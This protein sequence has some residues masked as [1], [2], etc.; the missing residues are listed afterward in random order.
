MHVMVSGLVVVMW[1]SICSLSD[2]VTLSERGSETVWERGRE[3]EHVGS[4][5]ERSRRLV[6]KI[7]TF[8]VVHC[9]TLLSICLWAGQRL[10]G[11]PLGPCMQTSC[12]CTP[13]EQWFHF[14]FTHICY[15]CN[16][17]FHFLNSF[18]IWMCWKLFGF[19]V[20]VSISKSHTG[21]DRLL[22]W[23]ICVYVWYLNIAK[24]VAVWFHARLPCRGVLLF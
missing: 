9:N 4:V 11:V 24:H 5:C 19:C 21:A 15:L 20:C 3:R 2:P 13:D 18:Y 10:H 7:K 12:P 16:V 1:S 22:L 8:T 6:S 23:H 17:L 14:L